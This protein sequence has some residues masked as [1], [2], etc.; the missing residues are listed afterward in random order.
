MD[1]LDEGHAFGWA[2]I[3]RDQPGSRW[4][5]DLGPD[6]AATRLRY[7]VS[8]GPGP[9]GVTMAIE[10]MPE[11]EPGSCTIAC[12]SI[13]ATWSPPWWASRPWWRRSGEIA[14]GSGRSNFYNRAFE[15]Q[16]FGDAVAEV[17]RLWLAGDREAAAAAVPVEIG[18]RTNLIGAPDEVK[19]RLRQYRDSGVDTLRVNPMGDT[20]E[21]QLD[22]LGRL[23]DLVQSLDD[24]SPSGSARVRERRGHRRSAP[25]SVTPGQ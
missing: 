16:G 21:A 10:S 5:F 20:L 9:S 17:Q 13:T 25:S 19:R 22:G 11:K 6:G 4:R 2:T 7:S 1:V 3:D 12:G 15:R 8:I 23:L 24:H 18:L 14:S